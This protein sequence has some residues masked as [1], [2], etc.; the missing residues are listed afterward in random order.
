MQ[1]VLRGRTGCGDLI[2]APAP[3]W[4]MQEPDENADNC[5]LFTH[6]AEEGA[7]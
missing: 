1:G 7:G 6:L 2:S 5:H 4:T 3:A